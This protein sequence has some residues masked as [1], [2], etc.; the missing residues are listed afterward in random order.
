MPLGFGAMQ[1]AVPGS[2]PCTL[3]SLFARCSDRAHGR[4]TSI[5]LGKAIRLGQ[6]NNATFIADAIPT[7]YH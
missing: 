5:A 3:H 7:I 6:I 4:V 1:L 2:P